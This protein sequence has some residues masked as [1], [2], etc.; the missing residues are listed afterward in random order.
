MNATRHDDGALCTPDDSSSSAHPDW[1]RAAIAH[2]RRW[3][4]RYCFILLRHRRRAAPAP[5]PAPGAN[6]RTCL[7]KRHGPTF[8]PSTYPNFSLIFFL[9]L[10]SICR[11]KGLPSG[12]VGD[13]RPL[14]YPLGFPELFDTGIE[15]TDEG[16]P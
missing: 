13:I 9:S 6:E 2:R 5:K 15:D 7:G 1:R 4:P 11:R 16:Y 3:A 8:P 14:S 10:P 12:M